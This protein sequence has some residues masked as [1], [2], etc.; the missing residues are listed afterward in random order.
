MTNRTHLTQKEY[1]VIKAKLDEQFLN[2]KQIAVVTKRSQAVVRQ[3]RD[4]DSWWFYQT[5]YQPTKI[6]LEEAPG[7]A[8]IT[9]SKSDTTEQTMAFYEI[10]NQLDAIRIEMGEIRSK[11]T[12]V[13][14]EIDSINRGI[15]LLNIR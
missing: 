12:G 8:V 5:K 15:G 3:V 14:E 1:E 2:M 7:K 11:L 6:K 13:N 4:T 10:L 9:G